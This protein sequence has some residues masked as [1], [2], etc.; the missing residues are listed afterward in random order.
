V[1]EWPTTRGSSVERICDWVRYRSDFPRS[2]APWSTPTGD[3]HGDAFNRSRVV[4]VVCAAL[5]EHA[6]SL[7]GREAREE[8]QSELVLLASDIVL[9]R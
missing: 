5:T 9:G 4:T 3:R 1:T 2:A 6:G 8:H 7:P